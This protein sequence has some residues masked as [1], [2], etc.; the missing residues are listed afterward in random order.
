MRDA[1]VRL[2]TWFQANCD[3]DWE[4]QFGVRIHTLDNP[5]WALD[6]DLSD[7]SLATKSWNPV[8]IERT[9]DD[10]VHCKVENLV[11]KA[12]GGVSNLAEM[13]ECFL[14]WTTQ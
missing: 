12:R 14:D 7:T 11:F 13:V 2:Q 8:A 4:H 5:G 9:D 1:L 6:I 10:W 3:G